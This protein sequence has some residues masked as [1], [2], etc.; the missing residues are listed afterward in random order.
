MLLGKM[1]LQQNKLFRPNQ[2]SRCQ[3]AVN[4]SS[5]EEVEGLHVVGPHHAFVADEISGGL[6]GPENKL[7]PTTIVLISFLKLV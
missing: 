1:H 3:G 5:F 6:F 4:S 2:F 7:L